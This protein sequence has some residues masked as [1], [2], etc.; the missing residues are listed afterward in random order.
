MT[1]LPVENVKITTID[2]GL[3]IV[4]ESIHHVRSASLGIFMGVGSR[5]ED[6]SIS[7]I[8]HFIEHMLFKGTN[9]R[10]AHQIVDEIESRGGY[11]N[12]W[13][14]KEMTSIHAGVLAEDAP[15]AMDIL[16]DMLLNS[17]MDP[18]E[19]VREKSVVI[20]E[21]KMYED[22]PDEI[23]H[24]L[25]E[26]TLWKKHPLGRSVIGTE[27]TVSSFTRE[28]LL[29]YIRTQYVPGRIV[30]S[31]VGNIEHDD[32]VKQVSNLMSSKSGNSKPHIVKPPKASGMSKQVKKRDTEQI[33]FC[34][35]SH[36]YSKLSPNRHALSIL[37]TVLGGNMSSRLF[38]EIR[39]KR[40]L[41]YGIG[42]YPK[43][44]RDAG[45][46]CIFGGT[47]PATYEQVIDLARTETDR[48]KSEGITADELLKA[49]RL[50]RGGLVLGLESMSSRMNRYG[51]SLMSHD[52]VI[53]LDEVL[54]KFDAVN[55]EAIL[56][57]ANHVFQTELIT[58]AAIGRFSSAK[59]VAAR[60]ITVDGDSV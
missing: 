43:F 56:D 2:N 29:D 42:S 17:A 15:L 8:S 23:I 33:N 55:N 20:E 1:K 22:S 30:I 7:G 26:E 12:A 3:R 27:K 11:P 45:S 18:E 21:I 28:N 48:I 38:Q 36:A 16:C 19:M 6:D 39:E 59:P 24:D 34:L 31:A 25:F 49:K 51:D 41:A 60:A 32:I 44:Y 35:G 13:T 50:V 4:T 5:D 57:V 47:S 52:R 53:P 9:T 14:D 37:S 54:D 58:L 46:F 40:G 10:T